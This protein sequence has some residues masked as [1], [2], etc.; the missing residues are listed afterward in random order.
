MAGQLGL[1]LHVPDVGL[2][3]QATLAWGLPVSLVSPSQN[4]TVV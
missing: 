2:L 3:A 4:H 1:S